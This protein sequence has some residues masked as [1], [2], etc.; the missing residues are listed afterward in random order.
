[1]VGSHGGRPYSV[2]FR[3]SSAGLTY[4]PRSHLRTYRNYFPP[5]ARWQFS[6]IR[7][8]RDV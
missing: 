1:M 7:L 4:T 5:E 6:G 3:G 8:A 2:F